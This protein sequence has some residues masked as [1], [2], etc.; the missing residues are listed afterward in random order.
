M[1]R[2]ALIVT[3]QLICVFVFAYAKSMVSNDAEHM[4][5]TVGNP[6]NMAFVPGK[7]SDRPGLPPSL[8]IVF[9]VSMKK[10][11]SLQTI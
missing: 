7:N 6:N 3:A 2:K 1:K 4:S 11:G 8:I 5:N 9:A 10:F